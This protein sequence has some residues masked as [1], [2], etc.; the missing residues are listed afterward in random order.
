MRIV[1]LQ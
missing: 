1:S